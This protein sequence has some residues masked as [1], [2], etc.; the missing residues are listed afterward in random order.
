MVFKSKVKNVFIN[1]TKRL[2]RGFLKACDAVISTLGAEGKLAL[3]ENPNTNIPPIVTKDGVS[4]INHIRFS[5]KIENFGALQAIQGALV[6]LERAGDST[7]TT[8][9][10]MQGYLRN[11]SRKKFNKKVEKGIK[12]AV[13]EVKE[14]LNNLS[15]KTTEDDL[16]QIIKVSVNNDE[17]LAEIIYNA[18]KKAGENGNVEIVKDNNLPKTRF[19]EQNGMHLN[20]HG[21]AS[22]HF[23]NQTFKASYD[24]ENVSVICAAIWEKDNTI[25]QNIKNFHLKNGRDTPLIVFIE[26]PNSDFT[27]EVIKWKENRNNVCVVAVNEY[28]EYLSETLLKDIALLTGAKV[29]NPRHEKPELVFGLADKVVSTLDNTTI[30]VNTPPQEIFDIIKELETAEEKNHERLK[31]LKGK[32]IIIEVGGM[33]ELQRKEEFDRVEDAVGSVKSSK[34]EG[35]IVG[36]GAT[37]VFIADNM[38]K[39]MPTKEIQTGYNLV[40]IVLKQP[41][42]KILENANRKTKT[43]WWDFWNKDY[44]KHCNQYG[45][46]YN[47]VKDEITDLL[48]D[49]IIDSK[50]AIRVA[51]ES[52]T[53]RAI[54]MLNIRTITAFPEEIKL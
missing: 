37:L 44:M 30:S 22:P 35:Y 34:E 14:W 15:F 36:G 12:T 31:R 32:V 39:E 24:S 28:D 9:S 2:D 49:G 3:L 38:K 53:E 17:D 43:K 8:A 20:R 50:K 19:I 18:F 16:K 21:Y 23:I 29:Y 7:T 6:T 26:R 46:G 41:F 54:Q 13:E 25:I 42:I 27:E 48:K 33:N 4:V 45:M 40:K 5:D 11:V 1:D 51:L 52:S 47:A 10:F